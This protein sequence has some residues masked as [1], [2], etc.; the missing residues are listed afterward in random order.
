MLYGMLCNRLLKQKLRSKFEFF[1]DRRWYRRYCNNVYFQTTQNS[2]T[3]L[4]G[5]YI[6]NQN[7]GRELCCNWYK[8][9]KL[10]IITF[11]SKPPWG[12]FALQFYVDENA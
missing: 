2:T 8:N 1:R 11:L 7:R 3:H 9:H 4:I 10:D 5:R 6:W 12:N